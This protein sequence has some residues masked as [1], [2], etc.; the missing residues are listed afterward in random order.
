MSF[1]LDLSLN[2]DLPYKKEGQ[3]P[4]NSNDCPM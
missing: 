2:L 4:E 1:S 3:R